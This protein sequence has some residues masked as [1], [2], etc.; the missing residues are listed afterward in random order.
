MK[1]ITLLFFLSLFSVTLT[2]A[3]TCL[4]PAGV[5]VTNITNTSAVISWNTA[6]SAQYYQLLIGVNGTT[7]GGNLIAQSSPFVLTGL[8]CDTTYT[9]QLS[10]VCNTANNPSAL[11]SAITFNTLSCTNN[12]GEPQNLTNCVGPNGI[13]CFDLTTNNAP[14]LGNANPN[15]YS[16][17]YFSSLND[18]TNNT[19]PL[20]TPFC[21]PLGTATIY[22]RITD[23]STGTIAQIKVFT[24]QALN[25]QNQGALPHMTQCDN[26]SN[27]Q[28]SYDLTTSQALISTINPL[29][30]HG[31]LADAQNNVNPIV[32]PTNFILP[33]S[34]SSSTIYIREHITNGCDNIFSRVLFTQLNC[35]VASSCSNANTLCN[36]IGVPFVNTVN[37]ANS[38]N[39]GCLGTTPNATW[40]YLPISQSG[41]INLQITQGNNAPLYNNLDVDYIIYGPFSSP[42]SGCSSYG[43]ANIVSCSYSTAATEY[44]FITNAVAGQYYLLMVTNFSN[45]PGFITINS[46]PSSTGIINCTGFTFNAFL[47]NNTNGVKDAG[48]PNF[49][50]GEFHYEKNN[51][52]TIHN[53]TSPL[54]VAYVYDNVATNS[55]NVNY[56]I[57]TNYAANYTVNPANYTAIHPAA[58]MTTYYFPVV[59]TNAYNDLAVT[60]I[61]ANLP[62]PGFN[63]FN[64]LV[65]ANL[66]NQIV[67]NGT[68]TFTKPTATTVTSTN[69]ATTATATGFTY[70]FTN[71][72]PFEVRTIDVI[73]SV[74]ALPTVNAGD[75]LISSATIEPLVGDLV[76]INNT[77]TVNQIVVNAYDPN[78]KMEAHGPQIVYS[79]FTSNDYLFYTIRFENT[80]NAAA[81]N[82]RVNDVLNNQLDETTLEMISASHPYTLDR[83]SKNLNWRFENIQLPVSVPNTMIGKGYITFKIKPKAG[84][85]IGDII[86]NNASI[87]FDYNPAI[88][89]NTFTTEFV[90]FLASS[91]FNLDAI[92]IYP[93][94]TSDIINIDV[95]ENQTLQSLMVY[96]MLGNKIIHKNEFEAHNQ[97]NLGNLAAGIYL[98]EIKDANDQQLIQKIIKK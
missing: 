10:S 35:N 70:N 73:M 89:T 7:V 59:A 43:S 28:I 77:S 82:I 56:T 45:Q 30:Y 96:D 26:D 62:R 32:N 19:L 38:G 71:L 65:Y 64:K 95:Q 4:P 78:D 47:D 11:T 14:I 42:I 79:N 68:V 9:V 97:L 44:P 46:M 48:E 17:N 72:L 57:N 66:S 60:V 85:A 50:L 21:M 36:S 67:S 92:K 33:T 84:F 87:Y 1:K 22:A 18:A 23:I 63:Y 98:L 2:H 6:S 51:D 91:S 58:G 86:P 75:Y 61:P 20:A 76:P 27:G 37:L 80:G 39:A 69:P 52:G 83:I 49:P 5:T 74:A 88:I 34:V 3:Q 16:I 41:N 55:Y 40:F 81:I 15:Q 29:T 12:L 93:N 90:S 25:Y 8:N 24:V 54:G 53:I 94:P 31:S 13:A